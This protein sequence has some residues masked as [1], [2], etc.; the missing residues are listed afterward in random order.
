MEKSVLYK[1]VANVSALTNTICGCYTDLHHS[2][3]KIADF[4]DRVTR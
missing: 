1:D 4:T 2:E 3:Q